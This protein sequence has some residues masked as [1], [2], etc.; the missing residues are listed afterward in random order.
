MKADRNNS[1]GDIKEAGMIQ[2]YLNQLGVIPNEIKEG[3][4]QVLDHIIKRVK[5]QNRRM[6]QL[7]K[8]SRE[9][10]NMHTQSLAQ[11]LDKVKKQREAVE[12]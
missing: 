11:A 1:E 10:S 8:F 7:V 3:L 2:G 6:I 9:Q 5:I 12:D 4:M